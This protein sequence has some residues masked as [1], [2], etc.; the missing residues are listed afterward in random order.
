MI[1]TKEIYRDK[2][3]SI[4]T[5]HLMLMVYR[6]AREQFNKGKKGYVLITK[7]DKEIIVES[8]EGELFDVGK[9]SNFIVNEFVYCVPFDKPLDRF[10]NYG[11][12]E[13]DII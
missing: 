3:D 11:I 9:V 1:T 13:D 4:I 12:Y 10:N 7:N 2:L 8:F 6:Y 5:H